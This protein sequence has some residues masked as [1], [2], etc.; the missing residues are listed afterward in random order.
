MVAVGVGLRS[1]ERAA[2]T[3][4][5]G[6]D[7]S[8]ITPFP[9]QGTKWPY[10]WSRVGSRIGIAQCSTAGMSLWM[11]KV[12]LLDGRVGMES[13]QIS[14]RISSRMP[15]ISPQSL[16]R[17]GQ[18]RRDCDHCGMPSRVFSVEGCVGGGKG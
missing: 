7:T 2:R 5:V 16:E 8:I 17:V 10:L 15:S 14:V 13:C 6:R 9:L 4:R 18:T 12:L 11:T 3:V 1:N